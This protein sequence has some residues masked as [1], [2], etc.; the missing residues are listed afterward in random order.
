MDANP[1]NP[2]PPRNPLDLPHWTLADSIPEFE[3][4]CPPPPRV[5]RVWLP[6]FLFCITC[7]STF[8]AG[9]G[10]VW[11]ILLGH[12]PDAWG[13]VI[14]DGLLYSGPV[15]IILLCHEMGHFLQACRY[16]VYA[17]LPYFIPMPLTPIGT[18]GAVIGMEPR[19]G[20][21][22]A[23]FDIGISGPLAGL[24]PSILFLW[25]GLRWSEYQPIAGGD[26]VF[27][28]PLLVKFMASSMLGPL[29]PGY[30]LDY[31]PV[32][33]AGWVGLL[34]TSINLIPIGQ[35]DGGHILY[36]LFR[37]KA[38][39]ASVVVL[40]LAIS[41]AVALRLTNWWLMLGLITFMGTRHPPSADDSVPLGATRYLLGI[42]TLA[43]LVIGF[44][45]VP[46]SSGP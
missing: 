23:V 31:H 7:V 6:V 29:P 22:K 26:I 20:D 39:A 35:L 18:F 27:G 1:L 45:P 40:A 42:L 25:L 8:V 4:D 19:S 38:H 17:S 36:G 30:F 41:A 2:Q 5:R 21:R 14:R 24:V 16:G 3:I 33:F 43:F 44:T 32:A 11:D 15:M 13:P 46:I 12:F 37:K 34:I 9:T 28:A 10:V